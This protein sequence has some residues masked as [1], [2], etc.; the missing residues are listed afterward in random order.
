[1]DELKLDPAFT[2]PG[3]KSLRLSVEDR[4][5]A[6]R[7]LSYQLARTPD[8]LRQHAQR[9]FL[10]IANGENE[11]L[12]GALVDL[13]IALGDKGQDLRKRLL[14][15]ARPLLSTENHEFLSRHQRAGLE[16]RHARIDL[17][18]SVLSAGFCE[19][20]PLVSHEP[21][22]S[23]FED[24]LQEALSLLEFGQLDEARRVLELA[25]LSN[26]APGPVEEELIGLYRH[27]RD[28]TRYDEL[29]QALLRDGVTLSEGWLALGDDLAKTE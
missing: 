29:T 16:A 20:T 17:K 9:I 18:G 1:M 23:G 14:D 2:I 27:T 6:K 11:P 4:S 25:C 15:L 7:F 28:R 24:P 21:V 13:F 3:E 12:F 5:E 10:L 19:S 26:P 22:P 8:N